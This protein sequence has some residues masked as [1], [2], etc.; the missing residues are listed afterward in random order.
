MAEKS[1]NKHKWVKSVLI[2]L[3][4]AVVISI[5][6]II[7]N[8]FIPV[9]YFTAYLVR[10]QN[11]VEG[12]LRVDFLN[13]GFGDSTLV[14]LPD[15]KIMLI[16]GGDGAYKN[17]LSLLKYLN[18]RGVDCIDFLICTSVNGEHCGGLTEIVKYKPVKKAFI[19]YSANTRITKEYYSLI[20]ELKL[21]SVDY[22]YASIGKGYCD[23]Q[24]ELFFTFLS[25]SSEHSKQS[26]Y[27]KMNA[28]PTNANIE[29]AS[30]VTWLQYK[31][32]AFAFTSDAHS[33]TLQSITERY[34]LSKQMN[35]SFCK[36]GDFSVQLEDCR[37]VTV[38]AHGGADNTYAPWYDIIS[39]D[40]AIVSV[41]ENFASL[42]SSIALADVCAHVEP[43]YTQEKGN[44]VIRVSKDGRIV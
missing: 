26:E 42:P 22:E 6:L 1:K 32:T 3:T 33:L 25:P 8:I 16:D 28:N 41:G 40:C 5:A 24:N 34:E 9:K 15:G 31:G 43:I 10:A 13:V 7:T 20:S 11:R 38:A 21:K 37:V 30:I 36:I 27:A 2:P 14:E 18:S 35:E 17:E 39:P 4:I 23:G 29:A 12:E 44:I 19:P